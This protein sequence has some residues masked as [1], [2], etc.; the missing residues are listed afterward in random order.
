MNTLLVIGL[1]A[2]GLIILSALIVWYSIY[3]FK[4]QLKANQELK[5]MKVVSNQIFY[6]HLKVVTIDRT[7]PNK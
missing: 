2:A 6:E 4:K 1:I 3:D 5:R 7:N